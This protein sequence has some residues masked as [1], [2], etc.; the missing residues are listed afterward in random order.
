MIV[1][2]G[3]N[4]CTMKTR[5]VRDL[6]E[7]AYAQAEQPAARHIFIAL[8]QDSA[9]A[10]ADA[11]DARR[12]TGI[13]LG[14]LDGMLVSVKD[15]FDVAGGPTSAGSKIRR[16]AIPA[17][18]D[19]PVVARMRRAGAVLIGRTNMSEFAFSGLG[20]NPHY[21]TPGNASA[22]DRVPGGSTSG[23]AVSVALGLAALTLGTDTGGSTRI[24]AAFNGIVGFKPTSPRIP[25]E[26]A[27]PLSYSLDSIGPLGRSVAE[28]AAADAIMAGDEPVPL[29][30]TPV[31]GLRIGVPR[32]QL[33][34]DAETEVTEAFEAALAVLAKS[35][36]R[37]VDV[38]IDDLIQD[39][40]AA[41]A[42][43]PIAA[44]EAAEIHAEA[45]DSQPQDF[46]QRV[47]GRILA[48]RTISAAA[49]I[50]TL[51]QREALKLAFAGRIAGLDALMLPT[52]PMRAPLIA[53]LEAD[54]ALFAATNLRALRNTSVGNFFDTPALSLPL[55]VDGLPIGLMLMGAPMQDRRLLAMGASVER[56]LAG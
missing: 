39:M 54:A 30:T 10:E 1:F 21:G 55:P 20:L 35:G 36:V 52:C 11:A 43:A 6:L 14:P 22:P 31:A 48:G 5:S 49:Y 34:L 24:P 3:N 8:M 32:G 47:L 15:L 56:A 28:C 27:F 46:D 50:R 37:I 41:L 51:R 25:K 17:T 7:Q 40:R 53:P 38:N 26:G 13:S 18:M 23:G 16:T 45:I 2:L 42:N 29:A 12:R 33:F 19:A 44:C 9:R 4:R